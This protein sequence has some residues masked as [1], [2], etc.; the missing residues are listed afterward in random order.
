MLK[1]EGYKIKKLSIKED[2][3]N[4]NE[5]DN[6]FGIYYKIVPNK[7]KNFNKV[8]IIEGIKI[9]TSN[10]NKY[11]IEVLISGDFS[12]DRTSSEFT[13]DL[14]TANCGAIL[15]PYLR[16]LISLLSSQV[17]EKILL[18]T[19]NFYEFIKDISEKDLYDK[20]DMFVDF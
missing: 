20:P 13:E 16:C 12:I 18:P 6:E 9:F 15:Y 10:D 8:N 2:G 4:K 19:M 7:E 11:T 17:N 5:K 14:L 3:F 1:F